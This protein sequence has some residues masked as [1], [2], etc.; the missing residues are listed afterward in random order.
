MKTSKIFFINMVQR[1]S[2]T[3]KLILRIF[4]VL[5][6]PISHW[7]QIYFSRFWRRGTPLRRF[8]HPAFA[9]LFWARAKWFVLRPKRLVTGQILRMVFHLDHVYGSVVRSSPDQGGWSL[10]CSE[11]HGRLPAVDQRK[12]AI[13]CGLRRRLA[14]TSERSPHLCL[15]HLF[16]RAGSHVSAGPLLVQV[17][18]FRPIRRF[19]S[20]G[21]SWVPHTL[22]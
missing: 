18:V 17:L 7:I 11:V 16:P 12:V 9:A 3:P 2:S 5:V 15:R 13:V 20:T 10:G 14:R 6:H 19:T 1:L 22:P 21:V 8:R 4:Q